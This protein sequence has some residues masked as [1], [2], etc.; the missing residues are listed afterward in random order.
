MNMADIRKA[1]SVP[2]KR[3]MQVVI[4]V[5]GFAGRRGYI[6]GSTTDG[7]LRVVDVLS[8]PYGWYGIYHPT[9]LTY[10][11]HKK[12]KRRAAQSQAVLI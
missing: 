5:G 12:A 1:Y 9:N 2:A 7:W 4:N 11:P 6:R 3:G 10:G 8:G